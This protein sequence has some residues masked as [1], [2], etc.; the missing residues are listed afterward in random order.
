MLSE[1]CKHLLVCVSAGIIEHACFITTSYLP[2]TAVLYS[3]RGHLDLLP[4]VRQKL[5]SRWVED[6]LVRG[7]SKCTFAQI[8]RFLTPHSCSFL[9]ILLTPTENVRFHPYPLLLITFV[10]SYPTAW[11]RS[12]HPYPLPPVKEF[13]VN[14]TDRTLSKGKG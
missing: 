13:V 3:P 1:N 12:F 8:C 2:C 7:H 4:I 9:L 6:L 14:T 10:F 5:Y 11:E